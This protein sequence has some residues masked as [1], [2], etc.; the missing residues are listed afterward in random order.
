MSG[1]TEIIIAFLISAAV[2]ITVSFI[3]SAALKHSRS[4]KAVT[5]VIDGGAD[6][7]LE[8]TV[9][10]L[11]RFREE[12]GLELDIVYLCGGDAEEKQAAR[13]LKSSCEGVRVLTPEII[14]GYFGEK[15]YREGKR[16][17]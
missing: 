15:R 17:L 7:D 3:K 6:G 14:G 2:I 9:R 13:L 16:A 1:T 11:L 12:Y 10:T 4:K 8:Q 5:A